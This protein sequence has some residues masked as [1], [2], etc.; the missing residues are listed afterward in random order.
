MDHLKLRRANSESHFSLPTVPPAIIIPN[1]NLDDESDLLEIDL[2]DPTGSM[3]RTIRS[4]T[5]SEILNSNDATYYLNAFDSSNQSPSVDELSSA[6]K[7]TKQLRDQTTNTPP[8]STFN[9]T[10]KTKKKLKKKISSPTANANDQHSISTYTN[11]QITPPTP[12]PTQTNPPEL[13]AQASLSSP[14]HSNRPKL[15]KVSFCFSLCRLSPTYSFSRAQAQKC[16][17]RFLFQN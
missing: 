4:K 2:T 5:V 10:T 14:N 9:S 16:H 1:S 17:I 15:Q 13:T 11:G 8:I 6:R 12:S 3:N 7:Q